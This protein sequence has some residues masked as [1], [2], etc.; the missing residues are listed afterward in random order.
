[1]LIRRLIFWIEIRGHGTRKW[2]WPWKNDWSIN[3]YDPYSKKRQGRYKTI[4]SIPE[5]DS[6]K[7]TARRNAWITI[8]NELYELVNESNSDWLIWLIEKWYKPFLLLDRWRTSKLFFELIYHTADSSP[9]V[10]KDKVYNSSF[11]PDHTFIIVVDQK[12][13]NQRFNPSDLQTLQ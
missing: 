3:T 11:I 1:M 10:L 9:Y 5:W 13:L 7:I 4:K 6:R 12:H 2:N 8:E